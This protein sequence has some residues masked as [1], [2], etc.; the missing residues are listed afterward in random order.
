MEREVWNV[1]CLRIARPAAVKVD[2]LG[3][4]DAE[5]ITLPAASVAVTVGL[6]TGEP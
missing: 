2:V 3:R 4:R 5:V 1:E 6:V